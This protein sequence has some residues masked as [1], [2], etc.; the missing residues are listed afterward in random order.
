VEPAAHGRREGD[1]IRDLAGE[2]LGLVGESG[3]GKTTLGRVCLG[4]VPATQGAVLFERKVIGPR[5]R[6]P[7]GKLAV[8]M[9]HPEWSLNPRLRVGVSVAGP[10]AILGAM[11]RRQRHARA[12][13]ALEM[14]GLG[15]SL[16][17][18]YPHELSGGQRQRVAIGRAL[19]TEP[20][21]VVFDEAVSAH[22]V[23]VQT[24]VLNV[25]KDLQERHGFAALFISHDLAATRYVSH[26]MVV[27]Y[28][29]N[30][31]EIGPA[32]RF[33]TGPRHPYSRA[34]SISIHPLRYQS[35]ALRGG[36]EDGSVRGCPLSLRCPLSSSRCRSEPPLL[37]QSNVACHHPNAV[38]H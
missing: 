14:V 26:R 37:D 20:R 19:I 22:D 16:A 2:T 11:T 33:Y 28:A 3:S 10:L 34:L 36:A 18:R 38:A 7:P 29:G 35:F 12:A 5:N 9:Q 23:S 25:I 4:L 21:F 1:D 6:P 32:E 13:Q 30:L 31:M 27:M 17:L 8:V 24:Q 15:A